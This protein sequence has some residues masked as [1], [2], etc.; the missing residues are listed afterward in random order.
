VAGDTALLWRG[1]DL[2]RYDART[3]AETRIAQG[4][5][6]NPDLLQVGG[7]TLLS[8]FVLLSDGSPVLRSPNE[9]PLAL[10]A[11]GHVLAGNQAPA[12]TAPAASSDAVQGP[13]RWLD[14]RLASP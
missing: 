9:R 14:A 2:Y 7:A 13:L 8:P 12:S 6:K 1:N 10:S 5:L 3:K 4:V 11:T